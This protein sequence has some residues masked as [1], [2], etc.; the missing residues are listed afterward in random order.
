MGARSV[1]NPG[2]GR[3]DEEAG[4]G[5]RKSTPAGSPWSAPTVRWPGVPGP[6]TWVS[7]PHRDHGSAAGRGFGRATHSRRQ[8]VRRA[9]R[10]AAPAGPRGS[11]L[12][13]PDI[14]R[15]TLTGGLIKTRSLGTALAG[16]LGGPGLPDAAARHRGRRAQCADRGHD[17]GAARPGLPDPA[18]R[19]GGGPAAALGDEQDT[20]AKRANVWSDRQIQA[21]WEYLLRLA[22]AR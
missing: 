4:G 1:R 22:S 10:R 18:D 13:Y 12:C 8:R 7:D 19:D 16:V 17:R 21:G 14:P 3:L 15:F 11:L 6:G 9:R 20:V 2:P 5:S